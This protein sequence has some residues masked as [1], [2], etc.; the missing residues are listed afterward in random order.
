MEDAARG[1]ER[2]IE[3]D[4]QAVCKSCTGSG[5]TSGSGKKTCRT[6]GGAGQVISSRGFFQV[7]QTCPDCGGTGE[8]ITYGELEARSNRLAHLLRAR[9]LGRLDHY[10]I[11]ME[12]NA[13]YVECCAAGERAGLYYTCINSYLKADELAY[14]LDNSESQLLITSASRLPVALEALAH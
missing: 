11:Y 12:N 13:R 5:S 3:Y 7:Q 9:G 14:I 1:I 10:A 4:R 2:E 8:T 6:C